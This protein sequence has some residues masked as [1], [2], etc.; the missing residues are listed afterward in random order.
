MDNKKS[1]FDRL[2]ET[3]NKDDEWW[4]SFITAPL[5]I[6]VNLIVVD[7]KW[8]TPNRITLFSFIVAIVS[9]VFIMQGGSTN[10]IVAAALIHA[11]HILDCMDGQMAR[12]RKIS[13]PSGSYF[14]KLTDQIQVALW[15]GAIGYAAYVQTQ[16]VLPVFLALIGIS[17]YSVRG[18]IKYIVIYSEMLDDKD[19]LNVTNKETAGIEKATEQRA[20]PHKGI[21]ANLSWLLKEQLKFFYFNEGVFI[22]MLSL[23]L[24]LNTLTDMLWVFAISQVLYGLGRSWQRGRQIHLGKHKDLLNPI[25]K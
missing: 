16:N 24:I 3:K 13:S 22:F 10:F 8:L 7:F 4:S 15:F 23:A 14:D 18:Y 2:W 6:M 9:T 11:S 20:G 1:K 19:Y 25:E 17:F 12:Y 21:L 5:A